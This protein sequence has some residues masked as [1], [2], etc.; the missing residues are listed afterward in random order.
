MTSSPLGFLSLSAL[1]ILFLLSFGPGHA[2]SQPGYR[3][4][5]GTASEPL[6]TIPE[7][8]LY[9]ESVAYDSGSGDYFLSSMAQSRI[10]RIHTDG[11]Y[12]DFVRGLE[13]RLQSSVG[14]KVDAQRRRLWVCTGRWTL[15]GGPEVPA[16][17]GVLL[18]DLDD[19]ALLRSWLMDQPSPG[20]IFNDIALAADGDAYVTTTLFG[21]IYRISPEQENME[22]LLDR[23]GLQTNGITLGPE[24]DVLFFTLD[25]DIAWMDLATGEVR[26]VEG[27]EE[28]SPGTDGLY[29]ID[30]S[31]V[32]LQPR[33]RRIV[34]FRLDDSLTTIRKV[35]VLAEDEETFAYP[36][37]GV[38][39]GDRLVYVATSYADR[40]RNPDS[41]VQH[42]DLLIRA[43]PL[44]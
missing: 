15:F 24:G 6:F 29:F 14:I 26:R 21:R 22:L 28:A 41:V 31:L 25:R 20:Q 43:L 30:G 17:T 39:V 5:V 1:P 13:P 3:S 40:P 7:H 16:V 42:P 18:F 19:G 33:R 10:L 9:P 34:R 8:D 11:S 35:E 37:T 44:R 12:E 36:T 2:P 23:P 4:R 27:P 38:L 32:A